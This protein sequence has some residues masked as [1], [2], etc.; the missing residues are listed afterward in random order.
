ME[1]T[2]A[3]G[4]RP[5]PNRDDDIRLIMAVQSKLGETLQEI[6]R[7]IRGLTACIDNLRTTVTQ[8]MTT[9]ESKMAVQQDR[10]ESLQTA[11]RDG[12]LGALTLDTTQTTP[13]PN[14]PH[15]VAQVITSRVNLSTASDQGGPSV[16]DDFGF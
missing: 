11:W 16:L 9:I 1:D 4:K 3:R 12:F 8:K 7:E 15:Y 5:R 13:L 2:A 6:L 10:I 14:I